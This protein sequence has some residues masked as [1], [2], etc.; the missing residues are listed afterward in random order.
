MVDIPIITISPP[1]KKEGDTPLNENSL[2]FFKKFEDST[3]K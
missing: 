3:K 2:E 1:K